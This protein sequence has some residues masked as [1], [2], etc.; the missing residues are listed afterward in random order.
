[1]AEK[2]ELGKYKGTKKDEKQ[3]T[4]MGEDKGVKENGG[5]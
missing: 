1:V 3:K 5:D 4:E 2:V